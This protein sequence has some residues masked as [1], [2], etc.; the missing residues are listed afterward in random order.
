MIFKVSYNSPALNKSNYVSFC[1]RRLKLSRL[2]IHN[3]LYKFLSN[4]NIINFPENKFSFE[5]SP[6]YALQ[7]TIKCYTS[8]NKYGWYCKLEQL[9]APARPIKANLDVDVTTLQAQIIASFQRQITAQVDA[10]IFQNINAAATTRVQQDLAADDANNYINNYYNYVY[11]DE[12]RRQNRLAYS[13]TPQRNIWDD[14]LPIDN[15]YVVN[16]AENV[17]AALDEVIHLD[18]IDE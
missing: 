14:L 13:A 6:S 10:E 11:N 12:N 5:V 8:T 2:E 18:P 16:P 1:E 7:T 17:D 15:N 4:R 9:I 3:F